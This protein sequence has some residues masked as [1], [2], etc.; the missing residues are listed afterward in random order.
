ML[1]HK[2]IALVTNLR[3]VFDFYFV[4]DFI[5]AIEDFSPHI[6]GNFLN[7]FIQFDVSSDSLDKLTA[8]FTASPQLRLV[9]D[10]NKHEFVYF[11]AA[12]S[13]HVRV[14]VA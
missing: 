10:E 5:D 1:S 12:L 14:C 11:S 13:L 7:L 4:F 9:T 8:C 6:A 3:Q 2:L